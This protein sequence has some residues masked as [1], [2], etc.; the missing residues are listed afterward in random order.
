MSTEVGQKQIK[1]TISDRA[2]VEKC[3]NELL[4]QYRSNIL[5]SVVEDWS[6]MSAMYRM[7]NVL[8]GMHNITGMAGHTAEA[9]RLS[10]EAG[11]IHL[12]RTACKVF[13]RKADQKSG[14][15][16]NFTTYIRRHGIQKVPLANFR[17]NRLNIIFLNGARV[18]YFHKHIL[19]FLSNCWGA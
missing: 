18:F 14:C 3:F 11:A 2:S 13:Q 4:E 15:T 17:G 1:S 8:C 10:G 5:P 12:I 6:E 9:T 19:D 7:Y 16:V